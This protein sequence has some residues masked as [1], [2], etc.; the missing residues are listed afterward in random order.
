[1]TLLSMTSL[2]K[3]NVGGNPQAEENS[4]FELLCS[5]INSTELNLANQCLLSI[6]DEVFYWANARQN[7]TSLNLQD[8]FL[9]SLSPEIDSLKTLT[10]LDLSNNQ[11]NSLPWQLGNLTNLKTLN[12]ENNPLSTM[13]REIQRQDVPNLLGFLGALKE[14]SQKVN[15]TKFMFVGEENVG[16]TSLYTLIRDYSLRKEKTLHLKRDAV[17]VSMEHMVK[18]IPE[19]RRLKKRSLTSTSAVDFTRTSNYVM[20]EEDAEA[21]IQNNGEEEILLDQHMNTVSTDGIDIHSISFQYTKRD[22]EDVV[23]E[24]ACW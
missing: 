17:N 10:S 9:A 1:M 8:N 24:A 5:Q 13:P 21:L 15:R 11:L 22:G 14:G 19:K 4:I 2:K 7:L 20:S 23:L 6:P 12:L 16:K 3:L 18:K